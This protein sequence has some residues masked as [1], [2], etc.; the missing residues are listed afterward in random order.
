M[1]SGRVTGLNNLW[2]SRADLVSICIS[3]FPAS[4]Q[5]WH[6]YIFFTLDVFINCVV[7]NF[8]HIFLIALCA[9]LNIS[10]TK[11]IVLFTLRNDYSKQH[12]L[13]LQV[14]RVNQASWSLQSSTKRLLFGFYFMVSPAVSNRNTVSYGIK[15]NGKSTGGKFAGTYTLS[16]HYYVETVEGK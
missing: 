3:S 12:W 6:R 10:F 14:W 8:V 13:A 4:A 5:I 1:S 9:F 15:I 11:V 7:W 16:K 2:I